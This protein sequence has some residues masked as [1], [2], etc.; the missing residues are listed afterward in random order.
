MQGKK[1]RSISRVQKGEKVKRKYYN[2]D[3]LDGVMKSCLVLHVH[4]VHVDL[5]N[6]DK[7]FDEFRALDRVDEAGAPEMIGSVYVGPSPNQT[8]DNVLKS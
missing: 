8:L 7:K 2:G 1:N 4:G 3:Y 5:A 6:L